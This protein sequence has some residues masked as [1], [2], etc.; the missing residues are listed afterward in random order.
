M[1]TTLTSSTRMT[2]SSI[3]AVTIVS[4]SA[5]TLDQGHIAAAPQGRVEIGELTP[6]G[7]EY[8]NLAMLPEV[9]VTAGRVRAS[10][11]A[12]VTELPEIEVVAT[13]ATARVAGNGR[14]VNP[15]KTAAAGAAATGVLLQ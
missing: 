7:A 10:R 8:Q 2:V 4:L 9:I 6:I 11:Y 1:F 5:L 12:A 13:R 14:T 15:G 3:A